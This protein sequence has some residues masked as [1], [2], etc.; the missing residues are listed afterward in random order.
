MNIQGLINEI[1]ENLDYIIKLLDEL[2]TISRP[3]S[4]NKK[5]SLSFKGAGLNPKR[6]FDSV[7]VTPVAF[8]WQCPY[9]YRPNQE[10]IEF[11]YDT[12]TCDV[13]GIKFDVTD[14]R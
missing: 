10:N 11:K 9:C 1:A 6:K 2:G 14:P 13:C 5:E 8:E 4:S 3:T 12:V 7:W